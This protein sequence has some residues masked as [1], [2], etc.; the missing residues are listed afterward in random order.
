MIKSRLMRFAVAALTLTLLIFL[1]HALSGAWDAGRYWIFP[2]V[3]ALAFAAAYV[4]QTPDEKR[5]TSER[6]AAWKKR[7]QRP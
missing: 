7:N 1:G 4:L 3:V 2:L 6:F 5:D